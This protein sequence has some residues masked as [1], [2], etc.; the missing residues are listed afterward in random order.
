MNKILNTYVLYGVSKHGDMYSLLSFQAGFPPG[1]VNILPGFGPT[2]G[3]AIASHMDIDKV[4]FTGSTE[5]CVCVYIH[6][7]FK[8]RSLSFNKSRPF[9]G[10]SCIIRNYKNSILQFGPV[11]CDENSLNLDAV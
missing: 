4:A 9:P 3:A 5:V 1:V 6:L 7:L 11:L 10:C 8:L 2:A